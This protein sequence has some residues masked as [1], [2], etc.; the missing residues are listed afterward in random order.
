MHHTLYLEHIITISLILAV[1]GIIYA[2]SLALFSADCYVSIFDIVNYVNFYLFTNVLPIDIYYV[3]VR[4]MILESPAY[5]HMF[6]SDTAIIK[7]MRVALYSTLVVRSLW[8]YDA[9]IHR[10]LDY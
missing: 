6:N 9:L 3:V 1:Q 8:L 10:G 7:Y 5:G 2:I 4:Y